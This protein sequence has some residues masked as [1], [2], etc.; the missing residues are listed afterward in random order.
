MPIQNNHAGDHYALD[1]AGAPVESLKAISGLDMV[2][3]VVLEPPSPRP[4]RTLRRRATW[5]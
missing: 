3:D 2:A 1:I 4:R 5:C